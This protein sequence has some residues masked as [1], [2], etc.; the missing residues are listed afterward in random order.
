MNF[1]NIIIKSNGPFSEAFL[2]LGINDFQQACN[3]IKNL[4]YK[5]TSSK[6]DSLLVLTE[7]RGTCSSKHA[8][9]KKLAKENGANDIELRIGI[10]KMNEQNTP[11]LA[12]VIPRN[13]RFIPEAHAYLS[14]NGQRLDFTRANSK[15]LKDE[16]I[17]EETILDADK[18]L[19]K[20][21][22]LHKKFVKK[23]CQ[24]NKLDFDEV[25]KMRELCIE[26]MSS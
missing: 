21:E 14:F 19:S 7:G 20:K 15:P 16:D 22:E 9:L 8:L 25:W 23:W 17:L 26:K 3:Y 10:Y 13:I 18:M 1:S 5:R 4:P 24:K 11:G 6:S 2:K 12:G